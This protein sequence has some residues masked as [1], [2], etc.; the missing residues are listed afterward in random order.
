MN[1]DDLTTWM[2][3]EHAKI[4]EL[5]DHLRA[6]VASPPHGDRAAWIAALRG[7]FDEFADRMARHL[8]MEEEGGYLT[9]VVELRPSL[10]QAVEIIRNE[11]EELTQIFQDVQEAVHELAATDVLLLRDCCKR[12]ECL[13][14]WLDRHEE[15]ENHLVVYAFTQ[16][17]GGQD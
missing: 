14:T 1:V 6:R 7:E 12:I 8:A 10:S 15:H 5:V 9:Q 2:L 13:L 3:E 4:A 17:W 16:D 11:H